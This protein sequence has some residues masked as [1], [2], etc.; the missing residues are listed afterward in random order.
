MLAD[1]RSKNSAHAHDGFW[2]PAHAAPSASG[3]RA[4]NGRDARRAAPLLEAAPPGTSVLTMTA[5][6]PLVL[7]NCLV[8]GFIARRFAPEHGQTPLAQP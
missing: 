3:R 4:T 7:M 5:A 8:I 2:F 1:G 6:C